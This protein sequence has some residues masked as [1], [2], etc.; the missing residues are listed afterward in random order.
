MYI[1]DNNVDVVFSFIK[2][3]FDVLEHLT[4]IDP[5]LFPLLVYSCPIKDL[6]EILPLI[7]AYLAAARLLKFITDKKYRFSLNEV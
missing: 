3:N 2:E 5:L 1:D 4:I 6:P 7:P